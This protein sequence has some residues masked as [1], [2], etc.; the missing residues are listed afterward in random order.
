MSGRKFSWYHL[1]SSK[2]RP[3][4]RHYGAVSA[5]GYLFLRLT[6]RTRK[7]ISFA[8]FPQASHQTAALWKV[9]CTQFLCL[10]TVFSCF[11]YFSTSRKIFQV[12]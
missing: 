7:W 3:C 6:R 8:R 10:V 4:F 9:S 1:I 11:W 2:A 12:F 5:A